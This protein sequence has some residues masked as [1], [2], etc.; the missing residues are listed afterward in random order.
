[1]CIRDRYNEDNTLPVGQVYFNVARCVAGLSG[2]DRL[3]AACDKDTTGHL[4]DAG[5]DAW[6]HFHELM[7]Q[8]FG[9]SYA[10]NAIGGA[11]AQGGTTIDGLLQG[12]IAA[13]PDVGLSALSDIYDTLP[14]HAV[15]ANTT[16]T[17]TAF[18]TAYQRMV[19]QYPGFGDMSGLLYVRRAPDAKAD[20][21]GQ[22]GLN[23]S[24]YLDNVGSGVE[25]GAYFNN[26]HSNSP[27][28]RMLAITDGYGTDLYAAL[29]AL[30]TP[31]GLGGLGQYTLTDGT[32]TLT[33]E[34]V[35]SLAL[36]QNIC[37]L[38]Y[39]SPSPRDVEDSRMPS[40][41]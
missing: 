36:G 18:R 16:L 12:V 29:S 7:D 39:T 41:A 23:L 19:S 6:S 30:T 24:G 31:V 9:A 3:A 32:I 11:V 28:I 40:S 10:T 38:L 14:G 37:C 26:S 2:N 13:V 27:R 8:Q 17:D 20:D 5:T 1:M 25:W 4:W 15:S 21:T 33:E 34:V 22:Y 35:A